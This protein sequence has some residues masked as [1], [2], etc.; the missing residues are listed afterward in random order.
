MDK[1]IGSV[2]VETA[3]A[4]LY[5]GP[6]VGDVLLFKDFLDATVFAKAAVH[7]WKGEVLIFK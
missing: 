5:P 6:D 2:F 1:L 3:F 7:H 4:G